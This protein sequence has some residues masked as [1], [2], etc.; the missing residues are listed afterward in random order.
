MLAAALSYATAGVP[1]FPLHSPNGAGGCS[2]GKPDCVS[3][4]K[5][6]RTKHGFRDATTDATVVTDWWSRWPDANIGSPTGRASGIDVLDVDAQHGGMGTL[7]R[8]E[9]EHGG[10]P[11]TVQVLTP[12]G[13]R[14]YLFR[15]T[16]RT[17]RS[18]AGEIGLG[19]DTR[20]EG[21]YRV[22]PPSVGANG[23]A[24]QFMRA[25]EKVT[26]ADPP[27]WLFEL[28]EQQLVLDAT[29]KVEETIPEGKRRQA[30]LSVAGSM[31][32]RGLTG[33][34]I[35]PALLKLNERCRPPLTRREVETLAADVAHRYAPDEESAIPT[36]PTATPRP[37]GA[38]L[39]TFETWLHLPDPGAL[40]A[41]LATVA[42]NRVGALDPSWMLVVGPSGGGKTETIAAITGLADV[43]QAATITE[44]ALLSGTPRREAASSAKGGLLREI[45][46]FGIL[47]LKDF[48]SVL[49]MHRD[50][51]AAVLA[52]LREIYDGSWTRL[53]GTDGGR[54]LHWSGKVG[55]IAGATPAI[56]Q[57]HAVLAQL[58]ERF[59]F[60]RLDVDDTAQQARRSLRHQG[61][62]REM[63]AALRDA[64]LGLFSDLDLTTLRPYSDADENRL[65]ATSMLVSRARSA[66]VRDS[67]RRELEL[68]PAAE[69]P[70]RLVGA[71]GR[72][73]TGLRLIG[74]ND[75][76]A[77]RIVAKVGLDSMPATRRQALELLVERDKAAPT[78]DVAA[79][80]G[81]P[82]PTTRRV[83][84]DLA[85]HG[86]I[87][88]E[89]QGQ[90]KADLWRIDAWTF[91]QWRAATISEASEDPKF[92]LFRNVGTPSQ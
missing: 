41:V 72:L 45:G 2:C 55:L 26:L 58:G 91:E 38:V 64:V 7:H 22:A 89:S 46:D 60:Y 25:P 63:R 81:L 73:L 33:A 85:A 15:H 57:H 14:H 31:R 51:R 43:H 39:E 90:G 71:L 18:G 23:R 42:A 8:L 67:Y 88:R 28:L 59:L 19:L 10:L 70:G 6:P 4:A 61:R 36:E 11:D 54:T 30:M 48:G 69:A 47:T 74:V 56:D 12:G 49:S 40:E 75:E 27:G 66:V 24:Y 68:V 44:A 65:V 77:W 83:L 76:E 62:E 5:H 13:G 53:V 21:G 78:T 52:A 82:T 92:D 80:L 32:R 79:A 35:L 17:L 3:A 86:L 20:G 9:Q 50:A 1:V 84:E 87:S 34:E 37:L 29:P 16:G